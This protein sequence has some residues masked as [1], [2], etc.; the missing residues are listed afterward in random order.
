MLG[1][2]L[3]ISAFAA[4]ATKP[5]IVFILTDDLDSATLAV[6]P[7]VMPQLSALIAAQGVSFDDYF[8]NVSLCC[9]SRSTIL[10]GQYSHNT[11]VK[12]NDP[13]EG[14]YQRFSDLGWEVSTV[15]TWLH[16]AGYMTAFAGKYLNGYPLDSPLHIPPGW[17]EWYS[18]VAGGAY[19]N[20]NYQM[21]E[22]G[23]VR[24]YGNTPADYLTDVLAARANA[25]IQRAAATGKPF[26]LYVATYAPHS[27][28]T[29]AP[30]HQDA[31]PGVTVPRTSSFNE[32]DVADK[33][34]WVKS[35]P[36]LSADQ[37]AFMDALYR[38]RL[39]SLLAVDDLV[40]GVIAT[41]QSTNRLATT[42]IFFS[43]D[44]G[45]HMGQHRLP[46]GKQTPYEEDIR[47]PLL[48]RGPGVPA[49]S[50][51]TH[52]TGNVDLAP[53]FAGLAGAQIP[54]WVDGVSLAP[55]LGTSPPPPEGWRTE[56][57]LHRWANV[58]EGEPQSTQAQSPPTW[59]VPEPPDVDRVT[60]LE[61]SAAHPP[62]RALRTSGYSYV[63]YATGE[64]EMYDLLKDPG[65]LDNLIR[66]DTSVDAQFVNSLS[67]RILGLETCAGAN[68]RSAS[69]GVTRSVLVES[70]QPE[71]D[72]I[73]PFLSDG[74]L[75]LN[76]WADD[77]AIYS[78]WGDGR[79]VAAH[80]E[81]TDC[82]I[83]KFTG[84]LPQITAE[85]RCYQAPTATPAVN[86]K[87]SSLLFLNR[88]LVGAFHSPMGNATIGYLAYSDDYGATWTRVGFFESGQA[89]PADASP[90]TVDVF[91]PFRCLFFVNMGKNHEFNTD[92][93]VYALGIGREYAWLGGVRLARVKA[94]EV[95]RYDAWRYFT[96]TVG[97]APTWSASQSDAVPL[98]GLATSGQGSAMYHAGIN[99]YLFMTATELYEAA[100][101]WGPWLLAG[102]WTSD[103][104]P[105][106]WQ[107]GYQ[108]G[109]IAKDAG[110][111]SFYF[112]IAG[113]NVAPKVTYRLNLGKMVMRLHTSESVSTPP[114]P[115]GAAG[116]NAGSRLTFFTGGAIS[117]AS[118]ALEYQFDWSG[119]G[120]LMSAWG[121]AAQTFSWPSPGAYRVRV[122]AR[123]A[124]DP[125]VLSGWS[126]GA[127]VTISAAGPRVRRHLSPAPG[128]P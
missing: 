124:A 11:W 31:F 122:R 100:D 58:D 13:P 1:A 109:L 60:A 75:W 108:P 53:T 84:H 51:R 111:D 80:T 8:V 88:R 19:G 6:S 56:Y 125:E 55:L 16:D 123:C 105:V 33:P 44:N 36:L 18:P 14:G 38:R 65:Q 69:D 49:G 126:A 10:R 107:G 37:I 24:A 102:A 90:W 43:S 59:G 70:V 78:G 32:A 76:T 73:K 67:R 77:D 28:A 50:R 71:G 89:P 5:N 118:H 34:L 22:N 54:D 42:Y 61:P 74:D 128:R 21:N 93:Y 97:G 4:A 91:S 114:K 7:P 39:Q 99:R 82:G 30:R 3:C 57:L 94:E 83:A 48:V 103:A 95:L 64:L 96:G 26:F 23:V 20:F 121:P 115:T 98:R 127:A 117:S 29:P 66:P 92:G 104:A 45:F 85:E 40:A 2:F 110:R 35:Q 112:T 87:P 113:Q 68:C 119:E 15:A 81:R 62:F 17:D 27:P 47:L 101:L 120:S 72:P 79:G 86:D 116:G 12:T 41:L 63:E 106:Q 9:P 46:Q 52:I 25:F